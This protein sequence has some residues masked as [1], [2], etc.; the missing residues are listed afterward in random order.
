MAGSKNG[1]RIG[2]IVPESFLF[3]KKYQKIREFILDKTELQGVI[4]LPESCFL[5]YIGIKTD[6]LVF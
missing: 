6:I 4:S 5:P 3:D 1:G 2:V